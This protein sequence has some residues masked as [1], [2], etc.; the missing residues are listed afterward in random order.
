MNFG[1][2]HLKLL[3]NCNLFLTKRINILPV[4]SNKLDLSLCDLLVLLLLFQQL[5]ACLCLTELLRGDVHDVQSAFHEPSAVPIRGKVATWKT[6]SNGIMPSLMYVHFLLRM[7]RLIF[8][9]DKKNVFF[10]LRMH[11]DFL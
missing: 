6:K 4:K 3:I 11:T 1:H 9:E 2:F 7:K 10:L 8:I 5:V